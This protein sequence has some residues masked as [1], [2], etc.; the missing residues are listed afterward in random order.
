[1]L[2]KIKHIFYTTKQFIKNVWLFREPLKQYRCWDYCGMLEFMETCARDMSECHKE[3]AWSVKNNKA[4]DLLIFA[5]YMKRI[6]EEDHYLKHLDFVEGE[7]GEVLFQLE[8]KP[9]T[10]PIYHPRKEWHKLEQGVMKN[11]EREAAKLFEK[12][13]RS[14]WT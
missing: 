11:Y 9:N 3:D 13:V 4:R 8:S 10:L 7:K 14:W 1:M 12:K 2:S 5:E 6:R